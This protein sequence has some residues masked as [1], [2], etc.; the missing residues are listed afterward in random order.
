MTTTGTLLRTTAAVLLLA[1]IGRAEPVRVSRANPR[2][3]ERDGKLVVLVT[4]DHHYGAV[5]DADFDFAANL[6]FLG[7]SGMNLTRIYPGGMFEPTDK[8]VAGNPLGPRPGRQILPWARSPVAGA[9]P[10]L[11]E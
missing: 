3:F 4:S 11:A 7:A 6:D 2:Y 5:I 1:G 9:H 8:Y 10:A